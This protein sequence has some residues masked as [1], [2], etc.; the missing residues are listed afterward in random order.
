MEKMT[1]LGVIK[2]YFSTPE[3]PVTFDELKKL[4][5][6]ERTELAEGAA[7]ELGVEIITKEGK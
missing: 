4:T 6:E 5:T 1:K 3:K 2:K 7:K